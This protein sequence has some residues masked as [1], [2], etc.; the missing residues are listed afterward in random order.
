MYR[1]DLKQ[2]EFLDFYMPFGGKLSAGNRWVKLAAM[3]PWGEIEEAYKK[4][5]DGTGMGA[6]AKSGRIAFG[7]LVIK[8]RLSITDE[9]T[10]EQILE[11]PYLQYFLGV[12]V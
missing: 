3:I 8:E 4:S 10:V 2:T 7:A 6:P 1:N 11:N 12:Q 5:L 9:E